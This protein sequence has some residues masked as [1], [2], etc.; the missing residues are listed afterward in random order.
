MNTSFC[1]IS[2]FPLQADSRRHFENTEDSWFLDSGI[3]NRGKSMLKKSGKKQ[4][5][6][7]KTCGLNDDVR[8]QLRAAKLPKTTTCTCRHKC[9]ELFSETERL[10]ICKEYWAIEDFRMQKEY[11]L[12]HITVKPIV[13]ALQNLPVQ[14]QRSSSREYRF[15]KNDKFVKVC[16]NFFIETLAISCKPIETAIRYTN[17]SGKYGCSD[18]RGY[19]K[20]IKTSEAKVKDVKEHIESFLMEDGYY[21]NGN[22]KINIEKTYERYRQKIKGTNKIPVLYSVYKKIVETEYN[23]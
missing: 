9:R 20:P 23:L 10:E 4:S 19:R 17:E 11:I 18:N 14:K 6:G 7:K 16:K 5:K 12:Q 3:R 8:R 15:Y 1:F 22:R 2:I 21:R 13:R